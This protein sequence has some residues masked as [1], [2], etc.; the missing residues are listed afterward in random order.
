MLTNKN[1]DVIRIRGKGYL[2][3]DIRCEMADTK[4]DQDWSLKRIPI[5]DFDNRKGD[6]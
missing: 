1:Q 4:K 3:P 2:I 6:M 5:T